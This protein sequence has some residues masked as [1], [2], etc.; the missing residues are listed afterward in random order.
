MA[1]VSPEKKSIQVNEVEF[2]AAASEGTMEKISKSVNFWNQFF[3]GP[4]LLTANGVYDNGIASETLVDGIIA[5]ES[6]CQ[7]YAF[8]FYNFD[9]GSAGTTEIDLIVHPENGD[10]SYSIF[11]TRPA[12]P[13]TA[14]HTPF[15]AI[16]QALDAAGAFQVLRTSTGVTNGVINTSLINLNAGDIITMSFINKQTNGANCGVQLSLSPR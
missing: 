9:A 16:V 7:I 6:N 12:I 15:A 10:P 8:S 3:T 2:D 11:T 14:D 1:L 5:C 13:S 4:R